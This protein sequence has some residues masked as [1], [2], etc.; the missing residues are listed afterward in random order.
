MDNLSMFYYPEGSQPV[1][2]RIELSLYE[3][4]EDIEVGE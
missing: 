4:I 1:E 3:R 2:E